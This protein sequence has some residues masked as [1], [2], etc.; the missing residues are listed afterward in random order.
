[1]TAATR[2]QRQ[3]RL[4]RKASPQSLARAVRGGV[5]AGGA[6]K[7]PALPWLG[8]L[9]FGRCVYCHFAK[10]GSTICTGDLLAAAPVRY[11]TGVSEWCQCTKHIHREPVVNGA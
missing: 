8:E 4:R 6:A 5:A 11:V 9:F 10:Q 7:V 1:M 2:T 3:R